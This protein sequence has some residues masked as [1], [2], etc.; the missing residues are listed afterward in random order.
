M[1]AGEKDIYFGTPTQL[2]EFAKVL[3]PKMGG[4]MALMAKAVYE[5]YGEEAIEV[6]AEEVKKAAREKGKKFTEEYLKE[7]GTKPEEIGVDVALTKIYA[8]SHGALAAA[9]LDLR[10][11]KLTKTESESHVHY[12]GLCEGW[13]ATWPEGTRHL[14]YIYSTQHDVGFMEGVHP[15]LKWVAH[16]EQDE[17]QPGLAH[18]PP[19]ECK[20]GADAKQPCIMKLKLL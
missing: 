3:V 14:C 12:C 11:Q 1:A 20:P 17:D 15:S 2:V 18:L 7:S 6:I 9:G 8:K 19:G 10:R 4:M 13:K 5:K 16:A